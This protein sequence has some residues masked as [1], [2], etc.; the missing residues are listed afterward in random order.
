MAMMFSGGTSAWMLWTVL[1][2]KPPPGARSSMRRLTSS[3]TS[4]GVPCG[5]TL[6]R[7]H[8]AAPED[9]VPPEVALQL[10]RVHPAR[11]DLDRVQD[12]H[13]D[14]DQVRDQ[15]ADRAAGV[16]E[17]LRA[18]RCPDERRTARRGAA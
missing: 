17:D 5:S 9:E 1:K 13:A 7:V 14:L 12:V 2:M 6:L 3:R 16:E 11:A 15:L 4:A 10:R 18:V 8:A